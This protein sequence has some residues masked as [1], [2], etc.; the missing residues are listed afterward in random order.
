MQHFTTRYLTIFFFLLHTLVFAQIKF[1]G[2]VSDEIG[3]IPGV[4]IEISNSLS[5]QTDF[6][7]NYHFH[8]PDNKNINLLIKPYEPFVTVEF[9]GINSKKLDSSILRLIIPTY[10]SISIEDYL[11]LSELEKQKFSFREVNCYNGPIGQYYL[12]KEFKHKPITIFVNDHE[13]KI[14]NYIFDS[15]ESKIVINWNPLW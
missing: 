13:I 4:S 7:G 6:D 14:D 5:T 12:C 15:K 1:S 2:N 10:N 3:A 11:A 8:L 9:K